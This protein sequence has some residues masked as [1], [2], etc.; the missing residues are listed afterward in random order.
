MTRLIILHEHS[1]AGHAGL[2]YTLM[3]TRQRF[4]IIYGV[5]SV[6]R[7]IAECGKCAIRRATPIRQLMADLP[8]CRVSATNK[9]FK[10]CGCDYLG[11][12]TYRQNRNHCKAWGLLFTC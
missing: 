11:P 4:W 2:A 5:S 7:Y 10:F 8:V 9:S 1:I 12:F 6:K 3:R